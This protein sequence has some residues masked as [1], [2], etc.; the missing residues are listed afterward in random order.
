MAIP[1]ESVSTKTG[2]RGPAQTPNLGPGQSYGTPAPGRPPAG[3][4]FGVTAQDAINN[5]SGTNTIPAPGAGAFVNVPVG[6]DR[7]A[8]RRR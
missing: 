7:P 2:N 4:A 6:E 3:P 1:P 5:H 8:P